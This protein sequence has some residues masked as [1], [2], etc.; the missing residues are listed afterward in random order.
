[1]LSTLK[2]HPAL[3]EWLKN[4]EVDD[5]SRMDTAE[6]PGIIKT[7]FIENKSLIKSAFHLEI[8]L[9]ANVYLSGLIGVLGSFAGAIIAF[10]VNTFSPETISKI[11]G[12]FSQA[13]YSSLIGLGIMWGAIFTDSWTYGVLQGNTIKDMIQKAFDELT[14]VTLLS[15]IMQHSQRQETKEE[16]KNEEE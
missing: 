14:T 3:L 12:G 9:H 8:L 4:L 10:Q 16:E 15:Y 2:V 13:L 7:F 6:L 1:M 11:T 5:I